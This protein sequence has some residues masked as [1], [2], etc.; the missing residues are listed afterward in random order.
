MTKTDIARQYRDKFGKSIATKTLA[1]KM[2]ADHPE[3]FTDIES[4]R[5]SLR[6]IEGKHGKA[7]LPKKDT[8]YVLDLPRKWNPEPV[9]SPARVLILDIETA[10]LQAFVWGIWNQNIATNQIQ[11]DWYC[12]TWAAKWLFEDKVYSGKLTPAEAKRGD[13]KRIIRGIWQLI[14]EA[15]IVIAHN[16]E[17]FDRPRLN[18]RFIIHGI[19]PPLPYITIDTLKYIRKTFGFTSNKLDY[20]NQLLNLPRK[21]EHTG[22]PMWIKSMSGDAESLRLMEEYNV[23]DVRILEQTYLLIR[24][25]IVP[26]PNMGLHI[27]DGKT[28]HCPTCGSDKLQD[29]GKAYHTGVN[30]YEQFRCG[31]CGATGRKRTAMDNVNKRRHLL[32]ATAR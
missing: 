4:A 18:Q 25:W 3:L 5:S 27:L 30:R 17:K 24:P 22:M 16:A 20:V 9:E 6:F 29:V 12:L 1:R 11:N 19:E 26:H 31:N 32:A 28:H 23:G 10:P 13:D 7:M 21:T 2:A 8:T 14:N 15:D